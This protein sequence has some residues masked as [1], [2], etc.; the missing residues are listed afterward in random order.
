MKSIYKYDILHDFTYGHLPEHLQKISKPFCDMAFKIAM[1]SPDTDEVFIALRNLMQVK[2]NVVRAHCK[3]RDRT[4]TI[5]VNGGACVIDGF[6]VSFEQIVELSGIG[7]PNGV[8]NVASWMKGLS[9]EPE[10]VFGPKESVEVCQGQHFFV[11]S[12]AQADQGARRG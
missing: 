12:K 5:F 1:E 7:D 8:L 9:I 10:G 4:T 2:D 6:R 3:N 11:Q